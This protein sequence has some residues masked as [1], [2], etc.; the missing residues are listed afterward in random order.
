MNVLGQTVNAVG[1]DVSTDPC[2]RILPYF[3]AR[4][5]L[6]QLPDQRLP[7]T[8][9]LLTCSLPS[10]SYLC[11]APLS[12]CAVA[13]AALAPHQPRRRREAAST[14]HARPQRRRDTQASTRSRCILL[15]TTSSCTRIYAVML[16]A[17]AFVARNRRCIIN[18]ILPDPVAA[19]S[20]VPSAQLRRRVAN[21]CD[22]RSARAVNGHHG[23][24]TVRLCGDMRLHYQHN[25]FQAPPG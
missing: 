11:Y 15:P 10:Q 5:Y 24:F 4:G 9:I 12:S 6:C 18:T 1:T 2:V 13:R 22:S 20:L 25:H 23:G 7:D 16:F 8:W 17:Y 14:P 3:T 21:W 19:R